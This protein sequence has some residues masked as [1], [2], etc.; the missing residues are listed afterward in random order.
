M[1]FPPSFFEE[2]GTMEELIGLLKFVSALAFLWFTV[3]FIELENKR[4]RD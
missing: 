1:D 2:L 3:W 4:K